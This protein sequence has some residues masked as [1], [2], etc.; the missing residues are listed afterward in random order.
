MCPVCR[1]LVYCSKLQSETAG[2]FQRNT[3]PASGTNFGEIIL[4]DLE[5]WIRRP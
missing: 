1:M 5:N 4:F 2:Y 3:L